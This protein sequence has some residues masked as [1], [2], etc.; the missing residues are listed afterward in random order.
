M[1][2]GYE[3]TLSFWK[4]NPP[5]P[6]KQPISARLVEAYLFRTELQLKFMRGIP[7]AMDEIVRDYP[8]VSAEWK[9]LAIWIA[10]SEPNYQARRITEQNEDT[11]GDFLVAQMK[12]PY[13]QAKA[14][15]KSLSKGT[16]GAPNKRPQTL[17]MLD[18][19]VANGWSYAQV[20]VRMCDCGNR[21]HNEKCRETIRKRIKEL[22]A[23]LARYGILYQRGTPGK[24]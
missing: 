20:A 22:D 2:I 19:M 9:E 23:L 5:D 24:K 1:A 12:M 10:P 15:L 17:K 14:L 16:K 18:A 11:I 8:N 7:G 4:A 13:S 6:T 21:S 3:N